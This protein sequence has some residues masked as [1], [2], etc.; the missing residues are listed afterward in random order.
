MRVLVKGAWNASPRTTPF[1]TTPT[2]ERKTC[3]AAGEDMVKRDNPA[4]VRRGAHKRKAQRGS[5]R[6]PKKAAVWRVD[7]AG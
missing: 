5:A 2:G 3:P 1:G 6:T 7:I 4:K